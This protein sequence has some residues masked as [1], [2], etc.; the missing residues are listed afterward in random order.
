MST[1]NAPSTCP[2]C[3]TAQAYASH[4]I[5]PNPTEAPTIGCVVVCADCGAV[6]RYVA[7]AATTALSLESVTDLGVLELSSR[8]RRV[9]ENMQAAFRSGKLRPS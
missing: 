7:S 9:I 8:E 6:S 2:H 4:A 5:G 1:F 3:G